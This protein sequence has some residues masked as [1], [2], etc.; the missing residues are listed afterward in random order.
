MSERFYSELLKMFDEF[1][2]LISVKD[3][4]MYP[5]ISMDISSDGRLQLYIANG[6][7]ESTWYGSGLSHTLQEGIL[8]LQAMID[9]MKKTPLF[10]IG[11]LI[12]KKEGVADTVPEDLVITGFSNG[13]YKALVKSD[14]ILLPCT[15]KKEVFEKNYKHSGN[16]LSDFA[17][18]LSG[19]YF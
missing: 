8:E 1:T 13:M 3:K 5:Y 7:H 17:D 6:S 16:V 2:D 11:E 4:S 10:K 19:A 12:V 14:D 15:G 9:E 18:Y